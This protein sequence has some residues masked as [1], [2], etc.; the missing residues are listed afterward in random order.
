M[1]CDLLRIYY[2]CTMN[3]ILRDFEI[4]FEGVVICLEFIIFAL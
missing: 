3:H 1:S 4:S 2:F